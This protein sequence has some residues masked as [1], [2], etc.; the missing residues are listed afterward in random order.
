MRLIIL[1]NSEHPASDTEL[2][3]RVFDFLSNQFCTV[4]LLI[5]KRQLMITRPYFIK[6]NFL[7]A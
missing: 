5:K 6:M 1:K 3:D 4:K 2:A 7:N